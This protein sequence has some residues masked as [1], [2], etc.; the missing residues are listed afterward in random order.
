MA[1]RSP[2]ND[3]LWSLKEEIQHMSSNG[4]VMIEKGDL[5]AGPAGASLSGAV[6]LRAL[7]GCKRANLKPRVPTLHWQF[8]ASTGPRSRRLSFGTSSRDI[9]RHSVINR[10]DRY[11]YLPIATKPKNY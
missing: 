5:G 9:Q 8:K 11:S 2:R 4:A 10:Y 6:R 1:Q 3:D 7:G